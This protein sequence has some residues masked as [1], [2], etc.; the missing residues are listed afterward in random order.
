MR[1]IGGQ[2]KGRR[3]KTLKGRSLRPTADRVKE[4]LFNILPHNL[5]GYKIL[6]LFAGTGNLSVEALS[7]GGAEAIMVDSSRA[8]AKAIKE[9]LRALGLEHKSKVW[10]TSVLRSIRLLSRDGKTFDI[11]FLD[12]PY[13]KGLVGQTLRAIA[14]GGLLC[15]EGVLVVEHSVREKPEST[16][17]RLA[18]RDQRR[19]GTTLLSF[20]AYDSSKTSDKERETTWHEPR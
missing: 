9:N 10:T 3:L 20:F 18:L 14:R 19:Y 17:G 8:A 13:E 7:R 16:Y 1:V 4:A 6:D 5:S 11:V 15:G 2:A 12:P